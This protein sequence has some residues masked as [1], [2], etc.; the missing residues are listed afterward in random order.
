MHNLRG[1]PMLLP[2][3]FEQKILSG[4][5]IQGFKIIIIVK[6]LRHGP[7]SWLRATDN[8]RTAG[9]CLL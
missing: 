2:P 7:F 9:T 1:I 8:G 3:L 5:R 6:A 4:K